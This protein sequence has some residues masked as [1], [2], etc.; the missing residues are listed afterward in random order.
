M[1][2]PR[3]LI[4][5]VIVDDHRVFAD[6]MARVL[7]LEPDL[8]VVGLAGTVA[9]AIALVDDAQPDVVLLDYHL[10]DGVGTTVCRQVMQ[11]LPTTRVVFLT[12]YSD[13]PVLIETV[14]AGAAAFLPKERSLTEVAAALR[15]VAQGES[16]LSRTSVQ[17][18]TAA[19]ARGAARSAGA[20]GPALALTPRELDVLT[21]LAQGDGNEEIAAALAISPHTVRTHVQNILGKLGVHSK[22]AA[23]SLA[24]RL[25]LISVRRGG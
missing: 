25:G 23:V 6:A 3:S 4:R 20:P 21:R 14:E 13:L 9:D 5:I 22:L 16:L 17:V 24:I 1:T 15:A 10:P 8:E 11:R 2:D 19:L 12:S 18:L 7:D